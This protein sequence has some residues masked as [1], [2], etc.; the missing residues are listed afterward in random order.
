MQYEVETINYDYYCCSSFIELVDIAQS[1][2]E[3]IDMYLMAIDGR[4][5]FATKYYHTKF[6][7]PNNQ[8]NAAM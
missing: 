6:Y 7:I 8:D 3:D 5:I 4:R 1:L 2:L